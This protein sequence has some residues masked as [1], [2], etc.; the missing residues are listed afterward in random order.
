MAFVEREQLW[1]G[2]MKAKYGEQWGDWFTVIVNRSHGCSTWKGIWAGWD[3]FSDFVSIRVGN[4]KRIQFWHNVWCG[5]QSLNILFVD[6]YS[7]A[8]E[9]DYLCIR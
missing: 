7:T 9:K 8:V 2:V 4:G 5:D 6:L 1:H 3:G